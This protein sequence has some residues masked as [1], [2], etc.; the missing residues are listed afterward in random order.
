MK[1]EAN[2]RYLGWS[3]SSLASCGKPDLR[4]NQNPEVYHGHVQLVGSL[5]PVS[6]GQDEASHKGGQISPFE[7]HGKNKSDVA[8]QVGGLEGVGK[9]T[10]DEEEVALQDSQIYEVKLSSAALTNANQAKIMLI[11][12]YKNSTWNMIFRRNE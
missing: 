12:W 3:V 9:N 6:E 2:I 8:E 10:E 7:Y 11:V 1:T 4:H 5:R